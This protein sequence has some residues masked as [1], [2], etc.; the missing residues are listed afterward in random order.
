MSSNP[1]TKAKKTTSMIFQKPEQKIPFAPPP[2]SSMSSRLDYSN[3]SKNNSTVSKTNS[4]APRNNSTG[5][6]LSP[7]VKEKNDKEQNF[8]RLTNKYCDLDNFLDS[9]A[10]SVTSSK[11]QT[12][13]EDFPTLSKSVQMTGAK[14][15]DYKTILTEPST[16]TINYNKPDN[17]P[18]FVDG[19]IILDY[20][21]I[22]KLCEETGIYR[23]K[24]QYQVLDRKTF[25][26]DCIGPAGNSEAETIKSYFGYNKMI[27]EMNRLAQCIKIYCVCICFKT[28]L[29]DCESLINDFFN[30]KTQSKISSYKDDLLNMKKYLAI[31]TKNTNIFD[32]SFFSPIEKKYKQYIELFGTIIT[33]VLSIYEMN[34]AKQSGDSKLKHKTRMQLTLL[35]NRIGLLMNDLVTLCDTNHSFSYHFVLRNT[36]SVEDNNIVLVGIS[37]NIFV[38]IPDGI[39][40]L[41]NRSYMDDDVLRYM[42]IEDVEQVFNQNA[43]IPSD[44]NKEYELSFT[45]GS[46]TPVG[47]SKLTIRYSFVD[48]IP[49]EKTSVVFKSK[50]DNVKCFSTIIYGTPSVTQQEIIPGTK[51]L[52]AIKFNGWLM[53]KE[54]QDI[55]SVDETEY[56][57]LDEEL[58]EAYSLEST[59]TNM[60]YTDFVFNE[61]RKVDTGN[62]I[63]KPEMLSSFHQLAFVKSD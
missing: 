27:T 7:S 46:S 38:D 6:Y 48:E 39:N 16:T 61:M 42:S 23:I 54:K 4:V 51:E 21:E 32:D 25:L 58:K 50:P 13:Q 36:S 45:G 31:C 9:I 5:Q 49:Y 52:S 1:A 8:N 63:I 37:K 18:I 33:D 53:Q 56:E 43:S 60:F 29:G 41:T 62:E 26:L 3:S 11:P 20:E 44:L 2:G 17:N 10:T 12:P 22:I 59:S 14:V 40:L 47:G 19:K 15:L 24:A 55:Y 57:F 30:I 35:A 34:M 28:I